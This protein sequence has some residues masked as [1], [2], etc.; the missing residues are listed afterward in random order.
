[1][2]NSCCEQLTRSVGAAVVENSCADDV[3]DD[4]VVDEGCFDDHLFDV[5]P[6]ADV[7]LVLLDGVVGES[8]AVGV[9]ESMVTPQLCSLKT[10]LTIQPGKA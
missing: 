7:G 4:V 1:M 10:S 6:L 5:G 9:T 8:G 3:L 2:Y